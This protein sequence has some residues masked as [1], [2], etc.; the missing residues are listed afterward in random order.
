MATEWGT[1]ENN[2]RAKFYSITKRGLKQLALQTENRERIA[3]ATGRDL[4]TRE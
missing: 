1:P 3:G 4:R 2:R